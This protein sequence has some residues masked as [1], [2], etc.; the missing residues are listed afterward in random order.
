[1]NEYSLKDELDSGWPVGPWC[2]PGN[3][4]RRRLC[5]KTPVV[6]LSFDSFQGR[7]K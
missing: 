1:V 4:G 3:A 5:S 7:W 2:P 6:K